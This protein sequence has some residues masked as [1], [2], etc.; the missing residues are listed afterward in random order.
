MSLKLCFLF[1]SFFFKNDKTNKDIYIYY[2]SMYSNNATGR[3]DYN[4]TTSIAM[5]VS[6]LL[7]IN[8][9]LVY[10]LVIVSQLSMIRLHSAL[11]VRL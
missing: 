4:L 10:S 2:Y 3:S 7:P 6:I 11:P 5:C 1:L 9:N 8:S